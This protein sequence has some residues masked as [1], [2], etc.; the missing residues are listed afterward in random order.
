MVFGAPQLLDKLPATLQL[1]VGGDT[2]AVKLFAF[3]TSQSTFTM[4][5][6]SEALGSNAIWFEFDKTNKFMISA[7]A[8]N[9]ENK[10]K[11]GGVFSASVENDGSLKRISA[12]VSP[13]AP[14]SIAISPDQKLVMVASFNG[15]SL[16]TYTLGSDAKLSAQPVQTFKFQGSGPNKERQG[17]AS[18]HQVRLDPSGQLLLVPDLGSDKIHSFA[19]ANGK[20]TPNADIIVK[21][22]CGPRHLEFAPGNQTPLRFYLLCELSSEIFLV[23]MPDVKGTSASVKQTLSA[24]PAGANAKTFNAA[25][26]LITPDGKFLY[27]TNRQK[28]PAG[29]IDD[30]IF[31]VFSRNEANGELKNAGFFPTGGKGPRHFTFS[32]DKAASLVV[33]TNQDSNLVSVHRRNATSG[34]L[35]EIAS[36]PSESPAIALFK[37]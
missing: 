32:P 14:V 22:G 23:E 19:L 25:E 27:A 17:S 9:F 21:P 31:A 35:N 37:L 12:S 4:K 7:S 2:K 16:T 11:T 8:A 3:D 15:G 18:A 10:E 28:D 6:T 1:Y 29:R 34:A 24:L 5:T 26:I 36:A 13:E 20:L 30:N 33:V